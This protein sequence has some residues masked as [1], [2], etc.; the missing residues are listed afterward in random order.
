M[1]EHR[2]RDSEREPEPPEPAEPAEPPEPREPSEPRE[3]RIIVERPSS[4]LSTFLIGLAIGAGLALLFAP[5]SG[6]ETRKRIVRGAR[7]MKRAAVDA[8]G[9]VPEKVEET[10][11]AARERRERDD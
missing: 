8:A 1:T 4:G 2:D 5:Q 10:F 6:A 9:D 3:P 11:A 7:R